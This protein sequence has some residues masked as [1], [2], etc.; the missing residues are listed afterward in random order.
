M[1]RSSS[2]V[3]KGNT[4][5]IDGGLETY[6]TNITNFTGQE[7]Y[8]ATNTFLD[9]NHYL[10][11][12]NMSTTWNWEQNIS[13]TLYNKS[14][15]TPDRPPTT[16]RGHLFQGAPSDPRIYLYGGADFSSNTSAHDY[17]SSNAGVLWSWDPSNQSDWR[18]TDI[19]AASPWQ[20]SR[21][22]RAEAPELGLGFY[23]NGE[24]GDVESVRAWGNLSTQ[25][26]HLEGMVVL[27]TANR[28]GRAAWNVSTAAM[29][30]GL[31]RTGAGMA[32]VAGM[33]DAGALVLVGGIARAPLVT[34]DPASGELVDLSAVQVWDVASW[35][36]D[37]AGGSGTW[38]GQAATGDVPELRTDFCV[39]TGTAADN[40][41]YNIYLYGGRNP[42]SG[43]IYDDVYALSLP[44]FTW[45]KLFTG[46]SPRWGHTCHLAPNSTQLLTLGGAL[47]SAPAAT[48]DWEYRGVAVLDSH[49][50]DWNSIFDA[51]AR[52]YAVTQGIA[53]VI[54]GGDTG[55]ATKT[56]PASGSFDTPA[57]ASLFARSTA[58]S[59][60]SSSSSSSNTPA[61]V[62]GVVGGVG[63]LA[64]L[65]ALALFL[66]LRRRGRRRKL[67]PE[68]DGQAGRVE[69]PAGAAERKEGEGAD[70]EAADAELPGNDVAAQELDGE[71]QFERIVELG[72]G[73]R[74]ELVGSG[75]G[76]KEGE[77][78][79]EGRRRR[80]REM[81]RVE[82]EGGERGDV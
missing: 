50:M 59:S 13:I 73:E 5:Y 52:P 36:D 18:R 51:S 79:E 9:L 22:A 69:A 64:L 66:V 28:T 10:L 23:L 65:A 44:S 1:T 15:S 68:M 2:S 75:V 38:Y 12:I 74:F 78:W 40:S 35:L 27:D 47:A 33:G 81:E 37:P 43:T 7:R 42:K 19:S 20:P 46:Q 82:G 54:G 14:A 26:A 45:I 53:E 25:L 21:G 63:G 34:D 80:E 77:A 61:I 71:D 32:Y 39:T 6:Y 55:A 11:G 30:G 58:G 76:T 29:T 67:P 16:L 41:S 4:L 8:N 49:T 24:A 3:L 70:V 17:S 56:L 62:G 48:C 31:P 57:L 72:G 60:S